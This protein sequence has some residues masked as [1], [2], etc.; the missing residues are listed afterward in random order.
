MPLTINIP[1]ETKRLALTYQH[2]HKIIDVGMLLPL[3]KLLTEN[4]SFLFAC[5]STQQQTLVN[6]LVLIVSPDYEAHHFSEYISL[7]KK[8]YADKNKNLVGKQ[9]I[10]AFT[11]IRQLAIQDET[12]YMTLEETLKDQGIDLLAQNNQQWFIDYRQLGSEII[13]NY[14]NSLNNKILSMEQT[15]T[16]H[17]RTH[18]EKVASETKD[19]IENLHRPKRQSQPVSVSKDFTREKI[20]NWKK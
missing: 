16:V 15:S 6:S 10:A 20:L 13:K 14:I 8:A 5:L 1:E 7:V 19:F 9:I 2:N 12:P 17:K 11:T 3:T 18:S 4:L